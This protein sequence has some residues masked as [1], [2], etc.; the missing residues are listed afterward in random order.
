M[1]FFVKLTSSHD[2]SPV[3]VNVDEVRLFKPVE[4]HT[5]IIF[6][7]EHVIGVLEGK[8]QI[9]GAMDQSRKAGI[10]SV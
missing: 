8:E 4:G 3:F 6:D 2:K 10:A 1:A 5:N 7:R 9:I